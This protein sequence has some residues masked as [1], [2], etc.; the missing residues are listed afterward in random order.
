MQLPLEIWQE[1]I[2]QLPL[3]NSAEFL[4]ISGMLLGVKDQLL[5]AERGSFL[6]KK[7]GLDW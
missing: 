4:R 6:G 3:E 2:A 7:H 5:G 1:I